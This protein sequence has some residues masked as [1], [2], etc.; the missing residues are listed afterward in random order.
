MIDSAPKRGDEDPALVPLQLAATNDL[1]LRIEGERWTVV[2][3]GETFHLQLRDVVRALA[4][5]SRTL[6][7]LSAAAVG[8]TPVPRPERIQ[9]APVSRPALVL[10]LRDDIWELAYAGSV[11][12][13]R[14]GRGLALLAHLVR[15][16]GAQIHVRELE[17][18]TRHCG[19][20][21]DGA[22]RAP[23]AGRIA[24]GLGDNGPMLDARAK[25][26][27]RHRIAELDAEVAVA[28]R[29]GDVGR[30]EAL[31]SERDL[32][33]HEIRAAIGLGGCDR[34]SGSDVERMRVAITHRIR[35]AIRQ[36]ASRHPALGKHL[37][38]SVRTG[39]CCA[40]RPDG[41]VPTRVRAA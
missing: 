18:I 9:V 16:P 14:D 15:R 1:V 36:I 37:A 3:A 32:V 21:G 31:R 40:Y 25:R 5:P 38:A 12:L 24:N 17:R 7:A 26:E 13:L 39:Y 33:A 11:I 19:D 2:V 23:C 27:Y 8:E 29:R 6:R 22:E 28:E 30:L 41:D 20:A 10:R 4:N 34:P 35:A